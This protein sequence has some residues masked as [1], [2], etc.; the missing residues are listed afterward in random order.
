MKPVERVFEKNGQTIRTTVPA[1]AVQL[2]AGG[3]R[4]VKQ[5]KSAD[6]KPGPRPVVKDKK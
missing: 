4:E 5:E 3:W 2:I 6:V 1:E